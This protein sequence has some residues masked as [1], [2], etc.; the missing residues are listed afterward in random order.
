MA[1][2]N[3]EH[4]GRKIR[5]IRLERGKTLKEM[6][7]EINFNYSNL[8]KVERGLRR[9]TVELLEKVSKKYNVEINYFFKDE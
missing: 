2:V 1:G 7:E 8:S 5:E 3:M 4:I 6:G 9:P